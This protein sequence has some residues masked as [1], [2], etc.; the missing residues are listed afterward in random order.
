MVLVRRPGRGD[1]LA[2]FDWSG[3]DPQPVVPSPAADEALGKDALLVALGQRCV[4]CF[5]EGDRLRDLQR[6][7]GR[8]GIGHELVAVPQLEAPAPSSM[9]TSSVRSSGG[10][11]LSVTSTAPWKSDA[12]TPHVYP[13]FADSVRPRNFRSM[14][15]SMTSRLCFRL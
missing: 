14:T 4:G 9:S 11:S 3:V 10:G 13:P 12:S 7:L 6:E 1:D 5:V 15:S 2:T 8:L